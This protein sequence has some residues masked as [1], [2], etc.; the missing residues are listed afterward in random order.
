[1]LRSSTKCQRGFTIVEIAVI[2]PILVI[3]TLGL[4]ACLILIVNNVS[5]PNR[6]NNLV[7]STQKALDMIEKDVVSS[8]TFLQTVPSIDYSDTNSADYS[9]IPSDNRLIIQKYDISSNPNDNAATIPAFGGTNPCSGGTI[10]DENN[11]TPIIVVYFIKNGSLYRR[12]LVNATT[13]PTCDARL[14][15]QSCSES[16]SCT[17]KDIL[18][19]N[20]GNISNFSVEYFLNSASTT[21]ITN[22]NEIPL[23]SSVS[24]AITSSVIGVSQDDNSYTSTLQLSRLNN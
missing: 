21:P 9:S 15:Q 11:T 3:V 16:Q 2:T 10:A 22:Y 14:A 1:M 6:Q 13:G 19:T 5:G 12:T 4:I 23:T 8:S 18:V 17:V 7:R 24:I 20:T